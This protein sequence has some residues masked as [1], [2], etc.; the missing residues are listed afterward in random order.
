MA[1][2]AKLVAFDLGLAAEQRITELMHDMTAH[3]VDAAIGM[4]GLLPVDILLVVAFG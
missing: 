2:N 3:A 1:G 4:P